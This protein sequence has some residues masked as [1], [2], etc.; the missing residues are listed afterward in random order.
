MSDRSEATTWKSFLAQV[1]ERVTDEDS[2]CHIISQDIPLLIS[3]IELLEKALEIE[4]TCYICG[5]ILKCEDNCA[6]PNKHGKVARQAL[7]AS[8]EGEKK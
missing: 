4:A 1:K 2:H 3:R 5:G 8:V 6:A 7:E